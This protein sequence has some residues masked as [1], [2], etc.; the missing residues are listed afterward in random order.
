MNDAMLVS[1]LQRV[2]QR[3]EPQNGNNELRLLFLLPA[4]GGAADDVLARRVD[5]DAMGG[6]LGS[7]AE[8]GGSN[9]SSR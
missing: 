6:L 7:A 4:R 2:Q 5:G 3:N 9:R 8:V 1:V